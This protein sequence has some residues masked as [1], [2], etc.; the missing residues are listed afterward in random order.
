MAPTDTLSLYLYVSFQAEEYREGFEHERRDREGAAGHMVEHQGTINYQFQQYRQQKD[1]EIHQYQAQLEKERAAY[2]KL[3]DKFD[4]LQLQFVN[5]KEDAEKQKK[6]EKR[7]SKGSERSDVE[8]LVAD[9]ARLS[10]EVLMKTH[11]VR[12]YEKKVET[13]K[14]QRDQALQEVES[15]KAQLGMIQQQGGVNVDPEEVRI[16]RWSQNCMC[17]EQLCVRTYRVIFRHL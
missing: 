7:V 13:Y 1:A 16:Y 15:Y 4:E 6:K 14:A 3:V 10:D 12:Q 11:Q 8:K 2:G 9:T 17:R 5:Y